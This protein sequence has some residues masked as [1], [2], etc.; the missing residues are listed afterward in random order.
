MGILLKNENKYEDMI[1]ILDH[2]HQY[3]PGKIY[4]HH[5]TLPGDE[6]GISFEDKHLLTILCGGDQLSAARAKGS[7]NVRQNSD[8][9]E[10]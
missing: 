5:V 4:S 10:Q 2:Y 8:T 7:R 1:D 9:S 6:S 3:V